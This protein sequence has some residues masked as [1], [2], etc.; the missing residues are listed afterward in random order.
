[1]QNSNI[2]IAACL[3]VK[4]DSE[5]DS[6]VKS[7]NSILPHVDSIYITATGKKVSKIKAWCEAKGINYSHFKWIDDFAA[8]RNFNFSQVKEEVDYI[9]WQDADDILIGGENLRKVASLG[10]ENGKDVIFFTY[11]YGCR[12]NGEPTAENMVEIEMEQMRERLLKPKVTTWRKRLHETP[13]P[14]LGVQNNYTTFGYDPEKNPIVVMHTTE[15]KDETKLKEKMMRNKRI[16]ELELEDERRNKMI[17]PRTILY[18]MKI[19][20][21][22]DN[23]QEW[24]KVI[25]MGKEYLDRSGWNEERATCW[26]QVGMAHGNKGEHQKAVE[27]FHNAVREWPFQPLVQIRLASSYFN[28]KEYK[29]A[30]YWMNIALKMDID[31]KGSNLTNIKAMK[32]M[33]ADLMLKLDY[34]YRHDTKKALESA[35]LVYAEQPNEGHLDQLVMLESLDKLNDA[36]GNFDKLTH[37]LDE[38]KE[39]ANITKM[40]DLLPQAITAQP[41]SFKIRQKFTSPR[42]WASNEICY[43]ANFG[44]K[45]FEEWDMSSLDTG[46]GGSETAVLELSKEWTKRGF[47]VTIYSDP[48]KQGVQDGVTI[49]PWYYFNP[50]DSFNIFIQWR[51]GSLADKI[52]AKK[53]YI[54]L[55]DVFG[56]VDYVDTLNRID[57]IMV[58]STYHKELATPQ[59]SEDKFSVI[60]NGI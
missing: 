51:N 3:I 58:K 7:V 45:H 8:A 37:Y 15:S 55:H 53:F 27:A 57:K 25:P 39:T 23:P 44:G 16:L 43:F 38:I 14:T 54:D 31:N 34:N 13:V 11:W 46:I 33:V 29:M 24:D 48:K 36:C 59:I 18:L 1:M 56:G 5:L 30:D 41:F 60:G 32:S 2:K 19:Y 49:L 9:Y 22:S 21:V 4:D 28:K 10:K 47:Q 50:A 20:A 52:K 12:F 42:V 26:E 40:L 6:L 35:K 17:D